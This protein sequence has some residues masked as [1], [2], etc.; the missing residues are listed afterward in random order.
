MPAIAASAPAQAASSGLVVAEVYGAGGNSGASYAADFV[1]L[2]NLGATTAS[3][4]GLSLVYRSAGGSVGGTVALDGGTVAPGGRYLVQMSAAGSNGAALPTPAKVA[5]PAVSMSS[6]SGTVELRSGTVAVDLVGYGSTATVFEARNT[7]VDLSATLSAQ[8]YEGDPDTDDN[9]ADFTEAQPTPGAAGPARPTPYTIAQIQGDGATSPLVGRT[10]STQGVVTARYPTGGYAGFYLQTGGAPDTPGSDAVFVYAP[11]L[12][13]AD[14]PFRGASVEV[15]GRVSEF[16]GSTQ[17]TLSGAAAPV[18]PGLPAVTPLSVPWTELDTEAE[19]EAHEGELVAPQGPFT[20]T[21]S[22]ATDQYGEIGLAA[23]TTPLLQPT[24]VADAQGSGDEAVAADN[25]RRRITLDDGASIDFRNAANVDTPLSW[26]TPTTPVRAGAPVTFTGP[27]VLE[28]RNDL[29]KFQPVRRITGAG[30]ATATFADTRTAAPAAVG[31]DIRLATF[32]VLNFFP[33]TG[34]EWQAAASGRSCSY[35]RDRDGAPTTVDECAPDGPRGAAD[36]ANLTRQRGKI[37]SAINRLGASVVSLEEIEN[38]AHFGQDRDA[39]VV[40]LV[41][42]LNAAAGAGTWAYVP[43][44]P[45][46]ELPP[47]AQQDVIR[48]AFIYRPAEVSPIGTSRVLTGSAAFA[49]AR[50]PLAQAFLRRG[51]TDT[52][53]VVVNHFKS[54]RSG[55]PDPDGQGAG[56]VE[57][58]AQARALDA[59][60]KAFAAER[61]TAAVFLTGD[62]NAYTQEDPVQELT[63]S[64]WT[65]LESTTAPGRDWSYFFGGLA[66]SLDHVFANAAARAMVTGVDVWDINAEEPVALEYSRYNGNTTQLFEPG[67]PYRASDHNPEVVG[68]RAPAAS[69]PA[70]GT[71]TGTTPA[72]AVRSTTG[73][74][75]VGK[76]LRV[77]GRR[78]KL[79]ISV[80]STAA[81]TGTVTVR[82]RGQ[83]TRT[84]TLTGGTATVR[85]G[86]FARAGAKRVVVTYSGSSTVL[87]SSAT[88]R[89][90]VRR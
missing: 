40:A 70:T 65:N 39:G 10:V 52:F 62:F 23:G 80:S 64:G 66:G 21:D 54:K 15:A 41:T 48:T 74:K 73:V 75:A 11:G 43:S 19:K 42:A 63:G 33:T 3:L 6:T 22:Y 25:A 79:S 50:E 77:D 24:D 13:P 59:F 49:D 38:S 68:L 56:N 84:V 1:E 18:S 57:R 44:P 83:R 51:G 76:R 5:A 9:A 82:V 46:S 71:G 17:I 16:N 69:T 2:R 4:D 27:V 60:A 67:T 32:N 53:S 26:L 28:Y 30:S 55:T 36:Q 78:A 37:V 31:G 72:L 47:V 81:V 7:G 85:L 86:R 20:V 87:P 89:L 45:A 29:W 88:L 34:V 90:R 35:Y 12:Q 8:R 58:V 61:G 14:V